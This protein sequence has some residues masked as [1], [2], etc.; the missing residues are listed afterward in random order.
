VSFLKE[1][2]FVIPESYDLPL[3]DEEILTTRVTEQH[4]KKHSIFNEVFIDGE[5]YDFEQKEIIF[6]S[7]EEYRFTMILPKD[8]D[9]LDPELAKMKY[10]SENRP[11]IILSNHDTSLDFTFY[12]TPDSIADYETRLT[13]YRSVF[14]QL[15]PSNVFFS[16]RIVELESGLTVACFD[17]CRSLLDGDVYYFYFFTDLPTTPKTEILGTFSCLF[18]LREDWEPLF[19]QMIETIEPILGNDLSSPQQGEGGTEH[20]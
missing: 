15:N 16:E 6:P 1:L 19:W 3:G 4:K 10:P 14:K 12:Y 5:L 9:I 20:A 11:E 17:L 2:A 13:Q 8:I 7:S 18:N